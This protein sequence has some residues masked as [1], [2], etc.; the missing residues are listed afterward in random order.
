MSIRSDADLR[1]LARD[2]SEYRIVVSTMVPDDLIPSVF[3]P[4]SFMSR[5]DFDKLLARDV[6]M[7][8]EYVDKAGPVAVNGFPMFM[9]MQMLTGDEVRRMIPFAHEYE[10]A[11]AA[12]KE[13]A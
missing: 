6:V 9:S 5:E 4:L 2:I 11:I 10:A 7:F 1:A 3:M 8:F 13:K 12:F